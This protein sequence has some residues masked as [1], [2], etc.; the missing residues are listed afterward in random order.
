ML[1]R[2]RHQVIRRALD[3]VWP[4]PCPEWVFGWNSRMSIGLAILPGR[5]LMHW[6]LTSRDA[7]SAWSRSPH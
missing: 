1:T 3:R 7:G 2:T 4:P 6:S 5:Q